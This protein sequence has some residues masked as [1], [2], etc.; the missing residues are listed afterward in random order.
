MGIE[1][2]IEGFWTVA[3]QLS[4]TWWPLSAPAKAIESLVGDLDTV[5]KPLYDQADAVADEEVDV[6]DLIDRLG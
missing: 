4:N 2:F 3:G 5:L 1:R 6:P